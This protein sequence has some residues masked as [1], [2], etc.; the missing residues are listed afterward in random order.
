MTLIDFIKQLVRPIISLALVGTIIKLALMG[1][2]DA[3]NLLQIVGV[4]IAFHFG[5]RAALKKPKL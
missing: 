3:E 4:V 5:E 2:I 1:D